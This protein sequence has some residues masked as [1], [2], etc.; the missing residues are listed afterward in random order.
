[1]SKFIPKKFTTAKLS[2]C[3]CVCVFFLT[4]F[5]DVAQVAINHKMIS[6]IWLK[7]EYDSVK[8]SKQSSVLLATSYL[9]HI[10]T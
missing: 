2:V 10:E 6:Q 3:V 7:T 1:M 9:S 4:Q 8:I 5:C